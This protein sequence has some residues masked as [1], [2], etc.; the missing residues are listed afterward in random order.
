[1]PWPYRCATCGS[2]EVQSGIHEI[3]CLLCGR[4]TDK[5]GVPVPLLAQIHSEGHYE[6]ILLG[7]VNPE[8]G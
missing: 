5:D 4:L 1:M 8:E 6:D 7:R 2:R 3:T